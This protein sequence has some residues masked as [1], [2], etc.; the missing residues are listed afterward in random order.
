MLLDMSEQ[1]ARG[2]TIDPGTVTF[3][4]GQSKEAIQASFPEAY[5]TEDQPATPRLW[6]SDLASELRMYFLAT[7]TDGNTPIWSNPPQFDHAILEAYFAPAPFP[8]HFRSPR[9]CRTLFQICPTVER[10]RVGTGH[11]PLDDC[12]SQAQTII[13]CYKHLGLA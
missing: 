4:L 5:P 11:N 13:N 2:L 10:V 12:Y 7:G 1:A 8:F 6:R 3:W 9:D